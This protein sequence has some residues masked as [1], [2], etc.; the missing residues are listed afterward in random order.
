MGEEESI[1]V[2]NE[3]PEV[4]DPE[5]APPEPEEKEMPE[6]AA[7]EPMEKVP[8]IG[9]ALTGREEGRRVALLDTFGGTAITEGA[10]QKAL[11][12]L[13]LQLRTDGSWSLKGPYT[14]GANIENKL[15]ATALAILAF[16]GNGKTHKQGPY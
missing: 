7:P 1:V 6:E 2:E 4:E 12:W 9:L 8:A 13:K 3:E 11:M 14:G 15:A 10:V 5:A 16:Q